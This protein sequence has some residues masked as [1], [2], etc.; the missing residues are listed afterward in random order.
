MIYDLAIILYIFSFIMLLMDFYFNK[1]VMKW[2]QVAFL[3]GAIALNGVLLKWHDMASLHNLTMLMTLSVGVV[4][5]VILFQSKKTYI[6][7]FLLPSI[8]CAS[9]LSILWDDGSR[10]GDIPSLWLFVHIPLVVVGMA[11]F[12]TAFASGIM[13]FILERQLKAK[14]F[15]RIFDRFPSL[16][17]IDKLNSATLYLGFVFYT[18]GILAA[19]GWIRFRFGDS[20][21][22]GSSFYVKIAVSSFAWVVTSVIVLVKLVR[23]TTARQTAF[24]SVIGVASICLTYIAVSFFMVR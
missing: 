24:A 22:L 18:A 11:F 23:V 2:A 6:G 13:Y 14:K 15:G 5:L 17:S 8:I 12:L 4:Y 20:A 19:L 3:I 7:F 16:A 21:G 9:L 1:T 10:H